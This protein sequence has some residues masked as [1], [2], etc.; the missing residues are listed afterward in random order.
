MKKTRER[1]V[2]KFSPT[3][4]KIALLKAG[5]KQ[6]DIARKVGVTRYMVNKVI[7]HGVG[8]RRVEEEIEKILE[9]WGSM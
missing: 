5:V 4:I 3:D 1:F 8:S 9:V 6:A 7:N 2:K